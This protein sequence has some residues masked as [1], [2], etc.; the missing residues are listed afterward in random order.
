MILRMNTPA[1]RDYINAK[2]EAIEATLAADAKEYQ[3]KT[4]T[5]LDALEQTV[6]SGFQSLREELATQLAQSQAEL[7]KWMVGTVLAGVAISTSITMA[8][9][10]NTAKAPAPPPIVIYT[11]PNVK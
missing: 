7:I 11:Q 5:R 10:N 4:N 3:A 9:L 8:L 1:D 2:S 6:Q